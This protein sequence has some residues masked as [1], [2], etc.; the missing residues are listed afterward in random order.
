MAFEFKLPDIGEG[1]V[2]G[3]IVQWLVEEGDLM[4]E[5]QPMVEVMTDKATVELPS[6]LKGRVL[7][8]NGAVGEVVEVGAV[9]IVIEGEGAGAES[10]PPEPAKPAPA[11]APAA[12]PAQP[13]PAVPQ[14][15]PVQPAAPRG[16]GKA[17]ATPAV[18][19]RAREMGIDISTVEGT[20]PGGRVTDEDLKRAQGLGPAAAEPAAAPAL[21]AP[22]AHSPAARDEVE[23]VPY[24]ALRKTIGQRLAQSKTTAPHFTY[25]EEVDMT[26]LV[27]LRKSYQELHQGQ[28]AKLTYLPFLI[29]AVIKGIR[30]HPMVNSSLM[31]DLGEI[32]VK[33]RCNIGIAT[34]TR[35]GLIVPV[36]KDADR[37][38]VLELAAEVARLSEDARLGKSNLDDLRGGTFTITSLGKLGGIMATPIIN[39]PEVAILCVHKIAPKP[40]VRE[41]EIVIRDMMNLSVSMDHRV[42][43][44][45]TGAAFLND[46]IPYLENPALL[47]L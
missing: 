16:G 7:K 10:P 21:P 17:L 20:G 14:P 18:R 15:A 37:K 31:D 33:K 32:H 42:V 28:V 13:A 19:R 40:V 4:E 2:E 27:R 36:V 24:R 38:D 5:D 41:G 44:G 30:K 9:L 22:A 47:L 12:A 8:R 1:V 29:K 11:P 6:P 23:I 25:V 3:E 43:D 45:M 26:E 46:I 34:D 35:N 39:Y